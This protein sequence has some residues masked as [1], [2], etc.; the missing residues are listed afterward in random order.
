MKN[1]ILIH[2][3]EFIQIEVE[4]YSPRDI[5]MLVTNYEIFDIS[6]FFTKHDELFVYTNYDIHF[7][8]TLGFE[9]IIKILID[10][11][12]L[13]INEEGNK[14]LSKSIIFRLM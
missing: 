13:F 12:I 8:T 6:L 10:E 5:A 1:D 3:T 7:T 9:K 11:E 4:L 14:C 2:I